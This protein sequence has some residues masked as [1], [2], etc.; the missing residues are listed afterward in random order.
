MEVQL[1]PLP[2]LEIRLTTLET[3]GQDKDQR[4]PSTVS[5]ADPPLRHQNEGHSARRRSVDDD[6]VP[7]TVMH[8]QGG[9]HR[10]RRYDD[11]IDED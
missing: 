10:H 5:Q 8:D 1:R 7:E 2:A 6:E 4:P 9:G 11:D 3:L